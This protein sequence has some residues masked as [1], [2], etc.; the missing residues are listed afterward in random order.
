MTRA[1]YPLAWLCLL[2][3]IVRAESATVEPLALGAVAPN[4]NLPAVDGKNYSLKDF[5]QAKLLVVLFTCNHC[6]TAQYYEDR[7]KQL[8]VDYES[9]GLAL[10]AINPNDPKSV[11]LDELGYTDLSDSFPEMKIR[12]EYKKFN[13][14]Y[15]F[16]GE[17]EE[18]SRAYGPVAT[19]HAFLFDSARKLRYVGRIDDSERPEFVK[20]HDLR[21]AIEALLSGREVEVKQTRTFGCSVK[22]AGKEE[23][24]K[25]YM[26]KLAAEPVSVELADAEALKSLRKNDSGKLRLVNFWATWCG[27]C[28][29]EFP[30]LI[31]INRMYRHRAFELVTVAANFPDEKK[32]VMSFL[33]KQQASTRNL[34]FSSNDKYKLMEAF[35]A[36]WNGA[37]PYTVLVDPAGGVIYKQQG[38]IDDLELKRAIVKFLKEDR[39]K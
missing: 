5:A 22:W 34:L 13:F 26:A 24:V 11:R 1:L 33:Q 21:D 2:F 29:T 16:D 6:P 19:P 15:L 8:V 23:S 7:I 9:R 25:S 32:E 14:P 30:E 17:N 35:D 28:I 39:F 12:A 31:T 38:P 18:V 27:P 37:L 20:T 10:V 3:G 36:E 4:F